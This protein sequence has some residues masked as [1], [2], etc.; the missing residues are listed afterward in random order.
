MSLVPF[1]RLYSTSYLRRSLHTPRRHLMPATTGRHTTPSI[2][3]LGSGGGVGWEEWCRN[4]WCKSQRWLSTVQGGRSCIC[5]CG[6]QRLQLDATACCRLSNAR[7]QSL[8]HST[9]HAASFCSYAV[10]C[11]HRVKC[12]LLLLLWQSGLAELGTNSIPVGC[13]LSPWAPP[14]WM[15]PEPRSC[16]PAG[17]L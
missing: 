5:P 3:T 14:Q 12:T 13:P 4:R 6:Q 1:L 17:S 10:C 2:A 7:K 15:Q 11:V 8:H 16:V 9:W